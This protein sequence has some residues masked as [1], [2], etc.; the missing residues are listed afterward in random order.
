MQAG[1]GGGHRPLH[2]GGT[3]HIGLQRQHPAPQRLHL[4]DGL[5]EVIGARRRIARIGGVAADV[6]GGDVRSLPGH[7]GG[8]AGLFACGADAAGEG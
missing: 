6:E 5:V 8:M 4:A 7:G 1:G 3:A 2:V